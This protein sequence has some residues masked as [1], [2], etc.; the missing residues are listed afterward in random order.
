MEEKNPSASWFTK[1][2]S[3]YFSVDGLKI[4]CWYD[5]A[6]MLINN[7]LTCIFFIS[8][9]IHLGGIERWWWSPVPLL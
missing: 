2:I 9:E 7:R 3:L 6:D 8:P 4:C 5:R 1:L